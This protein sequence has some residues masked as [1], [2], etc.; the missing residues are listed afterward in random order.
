M[1]PVHI[2]LLAGCMGD[3]ALQDCLDSMGIVTQPFLVVRALFCYLVA[4]V[5]EGLHTLTYEVV[6]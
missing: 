5:Y 2:R 4:I 6:T 3:A 1:Y